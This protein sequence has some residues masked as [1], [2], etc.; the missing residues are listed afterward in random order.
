MPLEIRVTIQDRGT[1]EATH[2]GDTD[3]LALHGVEVAKW[4]DDQIEAADLAIENRHGHRSSLTEKI[5]GLVLR[6]KS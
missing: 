2:F 5:V 1:I 3:L 4:L 6:K